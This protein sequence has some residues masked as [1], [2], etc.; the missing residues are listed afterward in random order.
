MAMKLI[1]G[2]QSE[3]VGAPGRSVVFF[4][5]VVALAVFLPVSRAQSGPAETSGIDSGNYKIQ[6]SVE[7]GYR[8]A[9]INGN[10][11]TYDTRAFIEQIR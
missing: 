2:L 6:Q 8:T 11:D 9:S 5:L 10:I 1:L 4:L 7:A 3:H